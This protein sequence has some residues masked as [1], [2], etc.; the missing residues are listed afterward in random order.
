MFLFE[1]HLH[2]SGCSDCAVSTGYEMV[3]AAKQ[4]G[5]SGFCLTNHF[6][7]GN[8]CV[9]RRLDWE[10]FVSVYTDDYLRTKE[11]GA[12]KGITVLFGLE[13][14]YMAGK[15]VLIYGVDPQAI[16]NNLQC[17]KM[18]IYEWSQFVHENG[19]LTAAAHPFRSR[20]YIPK[21]DE[22]PVSGVFDVIEAYNHC[23]EASENENA[24]RYAVENGLPVFS[25]GDVH[26]AGDFGRAGI[27]FDEK[28]TD[29]AG[30]VKAVRD[31]KY[32]LIINGAI[33][34]LP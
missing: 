7:H 19:G 24:F 28:V 15:E 31:K 16:K 23:N 32:Q 14:V 25:G 4:A 13:E 6:L 27:A 9:N 3:D 22:P 34:P 29:S 18:D 20:I 33:R 30:F 5:Y 2:T 17:K 12:S 1:T 11:Y 10:D 26:L 8:T 21:P